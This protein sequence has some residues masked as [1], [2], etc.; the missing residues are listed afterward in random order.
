MRAFPA[1]IAPSFWHEAEYCCIALEQYRVT[2][3]SL[4]E[5]ALHD[6]V[7]NRQ[8]MADRAAPVL[9][10]VAASTLHVV[11]WHVVHH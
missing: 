10:I 2:S 4:V 1:R 11:K 5:G 3:G 9:G 6:L 7:L 8:H